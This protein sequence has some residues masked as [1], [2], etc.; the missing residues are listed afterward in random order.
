VPRRSAG[1]R[2]G[3][4]A[5]DGADRT[6]DRATDRCARSRTARRTDARSD[7]MRSWLVRQ[8]IPVG[9]RMRI[10]TSSLIIHG[11]APPFRNR[12]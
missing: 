8:R 11:E 7:R 2:T 6:T 12:K 3:D 10:E 4:S 1:D 5:D 9:I